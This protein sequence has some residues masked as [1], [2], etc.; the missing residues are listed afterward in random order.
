MGAP[1]A[2][3]ALVV[4]GV[5]CLTLVWSGSQDFADP[6]PDCPSGDLK[7]LLPALQQWA[8]AEAA[9]VQAA[10]PGEVAAT[11]AAELQRWAAKACPTPDDP[12]GRV[13]NVMAVLRLAARAVAPSYEHRVE[14][15]AACYRAELTGAKAEAG[16][17]VP[18]S[19]TRP[20]WPEPGAPTCTTLVHPCDC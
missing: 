1:P 9:A 10:W 20:G 2:P 5:P 3:A 4:C 12:V 11:Y 16:L 17:T 18:R 6:V 13:P 19:F 15:V 14:R 7:G 8:K